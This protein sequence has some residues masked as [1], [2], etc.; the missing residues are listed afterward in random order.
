MTRKSKKKLWYL[1]HFAKNNSENYKKWKKSRF[2]AIDFRHAKSCTWLFLQ[3]HENKVVIIHVSFL[4][5]LFY[6]SPFLFQQHMK[7]QTS[8]KILSVIKLL[9]KKSISHNKQALMKRPPLWYQLKI[10]ICQKQ[11]HQNWNGKK[12]SKYFCSNI[13]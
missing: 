6:Y 7:C 1:R 13:F 3:K 11:N 10:E 8:I 2:W 9:H 12:N 5:Y 4:F